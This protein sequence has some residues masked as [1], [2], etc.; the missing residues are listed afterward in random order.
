MPF[1][2]LI[3][4]PPGLAHQELAWAALCRSFPTPPVLPLLSVALAGL[5]GSLL[6]LVGGIGGPADGVSLVAPA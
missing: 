5:L 3:H 6:Q 1:L 2:P 4:L